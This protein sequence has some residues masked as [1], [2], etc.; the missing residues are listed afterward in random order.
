VAAERHDCNYDRHYHGRNAP[1]PVRCPKFDKES[2]RLGA[3]GALVSTPGENEARSR[4]I[5]TG[6]EFAFIPRR[7]PVFYVSDGSPNSRADHSQPPFMVRVSAVIENQEYCLYFRKFNC[8]KKTH[9]R[10]IALWLIEQIN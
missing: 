9:G 8:V 1:L 7:Q 10:E 3:E 2:R 6:N 5:L 4:I